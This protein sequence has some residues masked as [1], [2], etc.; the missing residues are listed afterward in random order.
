VVTIS[1]NDFA[2][3]AER[4]LPA[5][6]VRPVAREEMPRDLKGIRD[7]MAKYVKVAGPSLY[8]LPIEMQLTDPDVV[9]NERYATRLDYVRTM[10]ALLRGAGYATDIV[11]AADDATASEE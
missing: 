8:E 1:S 5:V 9:L 7:W 3:A 6:D 10:C 11:F 4:L 2:K